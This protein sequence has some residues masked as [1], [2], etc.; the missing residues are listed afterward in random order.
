VQLD[1]GV[2]GSALAA[3]A[4]LFT[5]LGSRLRYCS[6]QVGAAAVLPVLP[7]RLSLVPRWAPDKF[8]P[9]QTDKECIG[10]STIH[11]RGQKEQG[12]DLIL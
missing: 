9:P 4:L 7:C 12:T 8:C 5:V 3:A 11:L 1:C 6:R 10:G 2:S